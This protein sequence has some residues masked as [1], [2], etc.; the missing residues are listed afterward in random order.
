M[1]D[2]VTNVLYAEIDRLQEKVK[3]QDEGDALPVREVSS[4]WGRRGKAM[5]EQNYA[6]LEASKR[7]VEVS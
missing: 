3:E 1:P 7:L 6:S 2:V 4:R 5:S